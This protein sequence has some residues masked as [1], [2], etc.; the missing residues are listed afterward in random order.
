MISGEAGS[1]AEAI[2]L[3]ALKLGFMDCGF[4]KV[5]KVYEVEDHYNQW[6]EQGFQAGMQYMERNTEKRLDPA[7][8]VE[9]AKTV[10][11]LLSNYNTPVAFSN[12]QLKIAKY[13][14]GEDYHEVLKEKLSRLEQ[15]ILSLCPTA[16]QRS[17]TDSAPVLE[18]FWAREASL[19]WIGRNSLLI[20]P[21]NGSYTFISVIFT[22]FEFSFESPRQIRDFCGSCTRCLQA[23]PTQAITSNRT[24]N[25]NKCISYQTIENKSEIP[26]ELQGKFD[27][28]IFGCDICQDVCPWNKRAPFH[29]E[30]RFALSS[31]LLNMTK[32]DWERVDEEKFRDL[33]K[34]SPIKRAKLA[35]LIRN[36]QYVTKGEEMI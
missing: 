22:S 23:C 27:N 29:S 7:L 14:Y 1:A 5:R 11:V 33:F 12:G 35:G 19:G 15:F 17:F 26:P 8:L 25:S 24:V 16:S 30:P 2:R 13:A 18:R 36:I 21:R 34:K 3:E 28:Y 10:I 9:G 20:S 32:T 31:A 6:I 4:A